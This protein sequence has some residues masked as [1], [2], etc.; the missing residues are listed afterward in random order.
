[1]AAF[2]AGSIQDSIPPLC[3]ALNKCGKD[4]DAGYPASRSVPSQDILGAFDSSIL[5]DDGQRAI[6]TSKIAYNPYYE[7]LL[8]KV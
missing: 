7:G 5:G 3:F 6:M 8:S 2:A 4:F 1:M